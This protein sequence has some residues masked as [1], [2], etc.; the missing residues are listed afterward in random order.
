MEFTIETK[1]FQNMLRKVVKCVS[2]STDNIMTSLLN[3]S[4]TDGV[5]C[6]SKTDARNFLDVYQEDIDCEDFDFTVDVALFSQIISK[7]TTKDLTLIKEDDCIVIKGNGT[8]KVEMMLDAGGQEIEFPRYGVRN[9]KYTGSITSD[10]IQTVLVCNKPSVGDKAVVSNIALTCYYCSDSAVVTSDSLRA[11]ITNVKM[12]DVPVLID[13]STFDLLGLFDSDISYS[14]DDDC[15]EFKCNGMKLFT[16]F[17]NERLEDYPITKCEEFAKSQ[18]PSSCSINKSSILAAINRISLFIKKRET[19]AVRFN[20]VKDG[21]V[22]ESPDKTAVEKI[23][24]MSSE[25]FSEFSLVKLCD[26]DAVLIR[27]HMLCNDIHC[28]F[29]KK[30]IGTYADRCSN[31]R[32]P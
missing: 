29:T 6:L 15:G 11:C 31:M 5:L 19:N 7:I 23:D 18:L 1:V 12:F 32:F 22:V 28:D 9:P 27:R 2:A 20:F 30:E 16:S 25:N 14:M 4:V 3:V 10:D 13:S 24:Y 17:V 8:Y 26:S 21:I